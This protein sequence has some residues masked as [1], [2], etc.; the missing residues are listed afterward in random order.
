M[1]YHIRYLALATN[2]EELRNQV[3]MLTD[4]VKQISDN[5]QMMVEATHHLVS[6]VNS[7]QDTITA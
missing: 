3:M 5:Q 1:L 7:V 4:T 2:V 6:G